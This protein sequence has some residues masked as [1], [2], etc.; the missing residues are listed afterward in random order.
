MKIIPTTGVAICLSIGLAACS[1]DSDQ[2]TATNNAT[3]ETEAKAVNQTDKPATPGMPQ[4]GR[5]L[6]L[7]LP[8]SKISEQ[9]LTEKL[10]AEQQQKLPNLFEQEKKEKR[11]I[12]DGKP[13][14]VPG[15]ALTDVPTV[16]GAEVS[17][18]VKID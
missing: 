9:E 1:V 3:S 11:V 7:R 15:E 10:I 4:S 6:D 8:A 12:V 14:F 17:I 16:D 18:E 5:S 2:S 13:S